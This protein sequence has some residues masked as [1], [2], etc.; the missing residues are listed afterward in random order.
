MVTRFGYESGNDVYD[1]VK[2]SLNFLVK[3][4]VWGTCGHQVWL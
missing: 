4:C 1:H 2:R 3:V